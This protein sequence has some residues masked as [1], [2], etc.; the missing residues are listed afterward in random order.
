MDHEN[1]V[2]VTDFDGTIT[3]HDFYL[4]A[5]ERLLKPDD[6]QPWQDYRAGTISHFEA[7]RRIFGRIRAPESE[8][9]QI[10]ADMQPDPAMKECVDDL[11]AA[12]WSVVVASAGCRWY[13]DRILDS[14]GVQIEVHANPGHYAEGGP[15]VMELDEKAPFFSR[16]LGVDKAGIVLHHLK[17][18]ARVAYCGDGT[19][20]EPAAMLVPPELRF[21][22]ADLA[23]V[24]K[25]RGQPF[26]AFEQ[27]SEVARALLEQGAL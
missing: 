17:R 19:T 2:L 3:R 27:W 21:A 5:V 15:L 9:L 4:L 23:A 26:R 8:A 1:S 6:L 10:V 16:E 20:D 11:K 12:G 14:L 7:I 24:L 13:V 22:R 25:R 18:G